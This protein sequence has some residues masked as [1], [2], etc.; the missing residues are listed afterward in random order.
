M[1]EGENFQIKISSTKSMMISL[2]KI[3]L[4][5]AGLNR[6]RQSLL[7]RVPKSNDWAK[8]K[9]DSITMK[10]IA[11]LTAKTGDEFAILKG[12]NEDILF[13]GAKYHCS[14]DGVLGEMLMKRQLELY[15]HSHP[16]ESSPF[17]SNDDRATLELIGQEKSRLISAVTGRENEFSYKEFEEVKNI[18]KKERSKFGNV[19]I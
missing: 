2:E 4:G 14:F 7:D 15:G 19:D 6:H 10:D 16:A 13:H 9:K 18:F 17:P 5:T 3:R 12:K 1:F 11:Y 8:F